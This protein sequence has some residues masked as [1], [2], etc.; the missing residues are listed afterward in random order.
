MGP[1]LN[2][3][4]TLRDTLGT[5]SAGQLWLYRAGH[6]GRVCSHPW[7]SKR[8][9]VFWPCTKSLR[10]YALASSRQDFCLNSTQASVTGSEQM[11]GG[12]CLLGTEG[13]SLAGGSLCEPSHVLDT[14]TLPSRTWLRLTSR[15]RVPPPYVPA[16][17]AR[18]SAPL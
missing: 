18:A 10:P 2:C 7:A 15:G 6:G 4:G 12:F 8:S 3:L 16:A 1:C 14:R 9:A 5:L 17:R 13:V 11:E